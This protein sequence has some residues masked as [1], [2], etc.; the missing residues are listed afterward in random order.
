MTVLRMG[1]ARKAQ[2]SIASPL[3]RMG[4]P[5]RI[6]FSLF[7]DTPSIYIGGMWTGGSR[8][9]EEGAMSSQR[10]GPLQAR[11]RGHFR[12]E[13]GAASGQKHLTEWMQGHRN[14]HGRKVDMP[15][16]TLPAERQQNTGP[17]IRPTLT[18]REDGGDVIGGTEYASTVG[19]T[20]KAVKMLSVT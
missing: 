2:L 18:G 13:R 15:Q 16:V 6:L 17:K 7:S 20:L 5:I 14:V 9:R 8:L 1:S 12:P 4:M 11:G 19:L 3:V 10:D